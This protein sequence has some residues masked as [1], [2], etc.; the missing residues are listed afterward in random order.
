MK[1]IILGADSSIVPPP[2]I[3]LV[4]RLIIGNRK[5]RRAFRKALERA[6]TNWLQVN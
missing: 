2:V 4:G 6:G 5:P 3:M 1:V